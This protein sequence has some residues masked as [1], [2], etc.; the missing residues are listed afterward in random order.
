MTS[1]VYPQH[2]TIFIIESG[3]SKMRYELTSHNLFYRLLKPIFL[4]R[5]SLQEQDCLL[6]SRGYSVFFQ[7]ES[8]Y[9]FSCRSKIHL[10]NTSM[11]QRI[12]FHLSYLVIQARSSMNVSSS[13][14]EYWLCGL[15]FYMDCWI[16]WPTRCLETSHS[17]LLLW[18]LFTEPSLFL[19]AYRSRFPWGSWKV[20]DW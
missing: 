14:G 6:H 8:S 9:F 11:Q 5:H 4:C 7:S 19:H 10:Q 16:L 2:N 18:Y 3:W 12:Y 15:L 13:Q 1:R 17:L 20:S